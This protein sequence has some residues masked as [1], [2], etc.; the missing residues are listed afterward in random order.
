MEHRRA[1][2]IM[3]QNSRKN[4]ILFP[5][6]LGLLVYLTTEK[7]KERAKKNRRESTVAKSPSR[8]YRVIFMF[9][10]NSWRSEQYS[11]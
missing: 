6:Y 5:L 8:H 1:Y 2:F 4:M 9:I 3:N 11:R 10:F 7:K